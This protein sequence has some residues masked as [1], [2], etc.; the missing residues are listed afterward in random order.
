MELPRLHVARAATFTESASDVWAR[1]G[2]FDDVSWMPGVERTIN[3]IPGK[4]REVHLQGGSPS[5]SEELLSETLQSHTFTF[6]DPGALP[7]EN[8]LAVLRVHED[9]DK[10]TVT[11]TAEFTARGA[12]GD[13]A[14]AQMA[15]W[16][17]ACLQKAGGT[18]LAPIAL[19]VFVSDYKPIETD[20]EGW[21]PSVQAT[22]PASTATLLTGEKDAVLVDALVTVSEAEE[23]VAWIRATGKNLTTVYVT[24]GHGDHFYGLSAVLKEFPKAVAVTLPEVI[25]FTDG[26]LADGYIAYWDSV[27]PG[28]MPKNPVAPTAMKDAFIDLEGH[29]LI[30][31]AVGQSDTDPSTVVYVPD[32]DA[33]V[34]G[35]VVYSAIHL[36]LAQTGLEERRNW[37]KAIA[38]VE[39]LNPAWVVAGHRDPAAES[40]SAAPQI[41]ATRQYLFDFSEGVEDGASAAEL[42]AFMLE[43]WPALGNPWTLSASAAAQ[44]V[45]KS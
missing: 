31:V 37:I 23:L 24:H 42:V 35:D 26:Q 14:K 1:I 11:W 17:E 15:G 32:L 2:N 21:D 38:I 30:P 9:G 36:W 6:S 44:F 3:V 16:Y 25:P 10:S 13:D 45:P 22:W 41:H 33:V 27:F 18:L 29:K 7:V 20:L 4:L 5:V 40:D 34:G 8:Y 39:E 12:T 28:Q 19:N 43:R